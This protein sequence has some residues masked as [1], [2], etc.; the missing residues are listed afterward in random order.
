MYFAWEPHVGKMCHGFFKVKF[1]KFIKPWKELKY[2]AI[3]NKKSI[4]FESITRHFSRPHLSSPWITERLGPKFEKHWTKYF[5]YSADQLWTSLCVDLRVSQRCAFEPRVSLIVCVCVRL[6][7]LSV[8]Y[9]LDFISLLYAH[10]AV[11]PQ[12]CF[13]VFFGIISSWTFAV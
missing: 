12:G 9:Y 7:C 13:P 3:I 8:I 2:R 4:Y 6:V 10:T 11:F 5:P 1:I